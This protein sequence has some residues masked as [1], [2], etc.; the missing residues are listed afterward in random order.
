MTDTCHKIDHWD[1]SILTIVTFT[2]AAKYY[3]CDPFIPGAFTDD[4]P[5]TDPRRP[6]RHFSNILTDDLTDSNGTMIVPK[7]AAIIELG[8]TAPLHPIDRDERFLRN[9]LGNIAGPL[10]LASMAWGDGPIEPMTEEDR[11]FLRAPF[12]EQGALPL[13]VVAHTRPDVAEIAV[14]DFGFEHAG[15]SDCIPEPRARA[16]QALGHTPATVYMLMDRFL[17]IEV[18]R[19]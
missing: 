13:A 18:T 11:A 16:I 15:S 8:F 3:D 1:G 17:S 7:G 6:L 14:S 5:Q 4:L 10:S 12:Q 9:M 19:I 2:E